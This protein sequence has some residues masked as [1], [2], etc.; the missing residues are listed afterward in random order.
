MTDGPAHH[1]PSKLT[2]KQIVGIALA[3]AL[4]GA[5]T[6]V[7]DVAMKNE[8]HASAFFK[9]DEALEVIF[10]TSI[11]SA[12]VFLLVVSVGVA[13]C[14]VAGARTAQEAFKV[15]INVLA[16]MMTATPI[17]RVDDVATDATEPSG[18]T[19]PSP[20]VGARLSP[21][22]RSRWRYSRPRGWSG[23]RGHRSKHR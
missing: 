7:A 21:P 9:I 17:N 1:K 23:H 16:I 15:G 6:I 2:V 3:A 8:A 22:F 18:L 20:K 5:V 11:A 10:E 12:L 4:G 13:L 19:Q 14:F